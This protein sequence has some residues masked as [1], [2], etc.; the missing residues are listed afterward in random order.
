MTDGSNVRLIRKLFSA[1]N[2]AAETGRLDGGLGFCRMTSS[3]RLSRMPRTPAPTEGTR[4]FVA[5]SR[6]GSTRSTDSEI[7]LAS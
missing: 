5:T 6:T 7:N 3:G 4:A 1:G 2:R